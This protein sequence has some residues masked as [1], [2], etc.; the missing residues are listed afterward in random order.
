MSQSSSQYSKGLLLTA[1]AT[2][3]LGG[4]ADSPS[5]R[6]VSTVHAQ[7][8]FARNP[9]LIL[10]ARGPLDTSARVDLDTAQADT[11][12][13]PGLTTRS[14]GT[15]PKHLRVIQFRGPVR[16]DWIEGLKATGSEIIGYLPNNAYLV[17]GTDSQIAKITNLHDRGTEDQS[18]PIRWMGRLDASNKIDPRL[19]T[20]PPGSGRDIARVDIELLDSPESDA[21]IQFISGQSLSVDH[22]PRRFL[23]FRVL[24]VSVPLQLLPAIASF[25]EVLYMSPSFVADLHDERSV[26][27]V[28][29]NL[30]GNGVEPTGPGYLDWLQARQLNTPSGGLVDFTDSGLDRGAISSNLVHPDFRD[31]QGNS[32][33]AYYFNYAKDGPEDRSGHG[34]LVASVA[35][36][37]G[38]SLNTDAAGYRFGIGVDP[39]TRFGVS[40]IFA[41]NGGL[42]FNLTFTSVA[43][44]AYAAGA[45]ISNNSWGN[46]SGAY[47]VVAQEYDALTRDA[48]PSEP[49]NQQM[50]FV[51]SAGNNG[52]GGRVSSPGTA[53]NVITVAASENFRPEGFD[54][55]DL[56]GLGAIGPAGADSALDIL[57][58]SSRGPTSDGRAKP[59]I[60]APGS[61]IYGSAS[62]AELF[63]AGGLCPGIPIYQP[64][65]QRL[66]TWSS[67]T[68]LSA[69]HISGT[70][71]LLT[72]FFV[73][74]NLLGD[75]RP[76]SPAMV[77]AFLT[78]S[79]SYMTGENAAGPLPGIK[80]GWGLVNLARSFDGARRTL[81]DQTRV[82]TESGQTFEIR[83]ALADRGQSLCVTL[84]WTDAPG[85]LAGAA[86]AN[87]LDLEV[88]VGDATIYRG[89]SFS[90]RFTISGGEADRLNNIE[91]IVLPPDEIPVGAQGNFTITVRAA[92]IS[93][94][95]VPGN[96]FELDQDFALVIYNVTDAV[97][98]PPP[99]PPAKVP[100]ITA[101][102]YVKKVL[103]VSGSDFS[104]AARVE[105]NGK[106]IEREFIF[107]SASG[108][109]GIK[110]KRKKLNLNASGDNSIVLIENDQRSLPFTLRL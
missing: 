40:R 53:K 19:D 69:P 66:Y 105:I 42:P 72:R 75:A 94:D 60:S 97:V 11:A 24:S 3:I 88:R 27:I 91:S 54:S 18:R 52:E 56:D 8:D 74:R 107:D 13:A 102:A 62:Q 90:G 29:G 79:A 39:H 21:A 82:L 71:S 33:V 63:N 17:R 104:A 83:G 110:L 37:S 15:T 44:A 51:F 101:A 108:T 58:F 4:M 78:N 109:L 50:L 6:H 36:G 68:S 49:G 20:V 14:D 87:D 98:D 31:T 73:H 10:F 84:A 86:L 32:R 99:P 25:D 61:H 85:M 77:K 70:A 106:L 16:N 22:E 100:V 43:A 67:G 96:S 65:G 34:S 93:S 23:R 103:T 2:V 41:A 89:N 59:D 38:M 55:C 26:Q 45:R 48:Q 30:T 7:N 92:N 46:G 1:I 5:V 9:N 76:P 47:D 57:S 64:P 95:G 80:Q 35:C 12:A 28:A 81:I